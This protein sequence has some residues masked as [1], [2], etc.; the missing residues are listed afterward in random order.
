MGCQNYDLM[1][2]YFPE[3]QF[4]AVCG[5]IATIASV[6]YFEPFICCSVFAPFFCICLA[7][8]P[9]SLDESSWVVHGTLCCVQ[10]RWMTPSYLLCCLADFQWNVS[11]LFSLIRQ[12]ICHCMN[13]P[14]GTLQY[15]YEVVA[16]VCS[17]CKRNVLVCLFN[18]FSNFWSNIR[19]PRHFFWV[20]VSVSAIV[21]I[22][23]FSF[24]L[25]HN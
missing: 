22:L 8:R 10:W 21:F 9:L 15:D 23:E 1:V 3:K 19:Y 25:S 12:Y 5:D 14:T 7:L 4:P 2:S 6:Q 11:I 13:S 17:K 24:Y 16:L 20:G 18:F